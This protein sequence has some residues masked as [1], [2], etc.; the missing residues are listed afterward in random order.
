MG[1]L[2]REVGLE[3]GVRKRVPESRKREEKRREEG[4][5][6]VP[7]CKQLSR[8]KRKSEDRNHS[9]AVEMDRWEGGS[10]GGWGKIGRRKEQR[11]LH[12]GV[13]LEFVLNKQKPKEEPP[14]FTRHTK[15]TT[16]K[17]KEKCNR[18]PPAQNWPRRFATQKPRVPDQKSPK[19]LLHNSDIFRRCMEFKQINSGAKFVE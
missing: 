2:R 15:K 3:F 6:V 4:T 19:S 8:K 13:E 10:P 5:I 9:M 12:G 16:R 7:V 11:H 1:L 17:R 14:L 18:G